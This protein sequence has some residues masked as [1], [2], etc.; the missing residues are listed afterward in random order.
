MISLWDRR[1]PASQSQMW[2]L[3]L[4]RWPSAKSDYWY[5]F[6]RVSRPDW[7]NSLRESGDPWTGKSS[8]SSH[9]RFALGYGIE[10]ASNAKS[11]GI[12]MRLPIARVR[13]SH[14]LWCAPEGWAYAEA[15]GRFHISAPRSC[16]SP[17]VT[18]PTSRTTIIELPDAVGLTIPHQFIGSGLSF[19]LGQEGL[20]IYNDANSVTVN[21]D[22]TLRRILPAANAIFLGRK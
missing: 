17:R 11:V 10:A 7:S 22:A 20:A 3:C 6:Q 15:C 16:P 19:L 9:R 18:F 14:N 1:T 5:V 2:G 13:R 8:F 4:S 12:L 21:S